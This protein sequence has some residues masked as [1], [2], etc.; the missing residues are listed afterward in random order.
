[1]DIHLNLM[2]DTTQ[3][4]REEGEEGEEGDGNWMSTS[5]CLSPDQSSQVVYT[6]GGQNTLVWKM[7]GQYR[8]QQGLMNNVLHQ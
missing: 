3:E 4:A 6:G 8:K 1:M 7:F 5:D 2:N